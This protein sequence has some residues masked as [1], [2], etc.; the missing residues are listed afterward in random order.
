MKGGST[1]TKHTVFDGYEGP[2]LPKQVQL[3]RLR[4]AMEGE[5]TPTQREVLVAYYIAKKTMSQIA[6][7]RGVNKSTV[8]R[9]IQRAEARL[10]RC[11]RY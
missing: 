4:S 11:L 1:E 5:L 6:A 7:E 3:R 8:C 2:R 9:I 10:Q